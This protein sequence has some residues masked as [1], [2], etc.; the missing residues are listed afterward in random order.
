MLLNFLMQIHRHFLM[1]QVSKSGGMTV[2][3]HGVQYPQMHSR[4]KNPSM[5]RPFYPLSLNLTQTSLSLYKPSVSALERA[6]Q[7]KT[8]LQI[9]KGFSTHRK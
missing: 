5:E 8:E 9:Y 1:T 2:W 3:N 7:K 4:M 6:G